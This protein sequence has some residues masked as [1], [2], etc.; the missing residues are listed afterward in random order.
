MGRA[1]FGSVAVP[2]HR[3]TRSVD[4]V[5]RQ[6]GESFEH[7]PP[8]QELAA[9]IQGLGQGWSQAQFG[10]SR[11]QAGRGGARQPGLWPPARPLPCSQGT[12]P[13]AVAASQCSPTGTS[14]LSSSARASEL[15][16]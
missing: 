7:R 6:G 12:G 4:P 14:T 5:T 3:Q 9:Q 16:R 15:P 1:P 13:P 2:E 8:C 10:G 11:V